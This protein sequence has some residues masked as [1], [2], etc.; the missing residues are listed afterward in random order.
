MLLLTKP[1]KLSPP[2]HPVSMMGR[3]DGNVKPH[4]MMLSNFCRSPAWYTYALWVYAAGQHGHRR[5]DVA[6]RSATANGSAAWPSGRCAYWSGACGGSKRCGRFRQTSPACA[7]GWSR[8]WRT[9]RGA[10]KRIRRRYR[11]AEFEPFGPLVYLIE[12]AIGVSL[13]LGLL[14]RLGALL[15]LLMGSIFGWG[16]IRFRRVALDLY[17]SDHHPGAVRRRSAWPRPWRRRAH[18][19]AHR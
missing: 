8:R 11:V 16:S 1:E 15:G 12:V 9:Q 7:T 5:I 17:V 6:A 2:S 19:V 14:S 3:S 4:C 13:L 18:A 10:A